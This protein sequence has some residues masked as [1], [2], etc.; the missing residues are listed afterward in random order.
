MIKQNILLVDD[1]KENLIALEAILDSPKRNL[2]MATSGNEALQIALKKDLSLILLDVQMPGMDGFEVAELLHQNRRT[3]SIPIIFVTAISQ[4]EKYVYRGYDSGAVDFLSKPLDETIL[5][6]KV[7]VFLELD[8]QKKRLQQAIVQ[9]KR[10]KDENERLLLALSEAVVS[11]D[12][13]GRIT[14]C[15]DTAC[16][17]LG[18]ERQSV[19]GAN[20]A[21]LFFRDNTGDMLWS[22]ADSPLYMTC[23]NGQR[24]Q[25]TGIPLYIGNKAHA[26]PIE[27]SAS[28][29]SEDQFNGAVV[30]FREVRQLDETDPDKLAKAARAHPRKKMFK[31]LVIFD[32]NTGGNV[33]KLL[34][35]SQGGFKMFTRNKLENGQGMA[36]CL[37]LPQQIQGVTTLT[38]NAH[39]QWQKGNE[40]STEYHVGCKFS[41]LSANSEGIIQELLEMI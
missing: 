33:G 5:K 7:D 35:I 37:V 26:R 17:L 28:S 30:T 34:D 15:N 39:V 24:W 23:S 12:A 22:W 14:F 20:F 2:L 21:E 32:K 16:V 18:V 1:H 27:L 11:T 25:S 10:L 19:I 4:E 8:A 31:D 29:I 3:K 13:Q 9:M 36:L 40:D 38:F 41:G 6:A